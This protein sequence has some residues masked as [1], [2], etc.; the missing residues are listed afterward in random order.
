MT[1]LSGKTALVTGGNRG[2]GLEVVRALAKAGATVHFTARNAANIAAAQRDLGPI[3]ATGHLANM[4]DRA[5]MTTVLEHGFDILINNAGVIGPIGRMLD[6]SPEDWA[7]NIETNLIAAFQASQTAM[8][9]MVAKGGGTI[10]NLSSGAA[11]RPMEGWSA[12]CAGKAG[13]AMLTRSIHEEYAAQGIRV[14]G[15][16]PGVVDTDMQGA[17]RASGINPVS[18]IPRENLAPADEPARA[19]AWLCTP[20]ADAYAGQELDVRNPDLRAQVGLR[21]LP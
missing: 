4:T 20:A 21:A 11:H 15:F 16:A 6:I 17:I 2:I 10:V 12:Y 18:K 8:R 13:L 9:Q 19:I 7:I 3:K 5:A 1:P 14:F